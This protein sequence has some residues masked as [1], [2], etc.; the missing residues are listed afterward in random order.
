MAQPARRHAILWLRRDLRRADHPGLA[1][2][3]QAGGEAGIVALFVLDPALWA[4]AGTARRAWLAA[5]VRAAAESYEGRLCVR[6][7]DPRTVLPDVAREAG[8]ATVHVS[9]ET[10]P[11]GV[12]RDA[13]V[14]RSLSEAE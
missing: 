4:R 8:A 7:G 5:S 9:R 14:Q 11:V 13:A 1:A 3:A 10:T 2:A 6:V 12:R